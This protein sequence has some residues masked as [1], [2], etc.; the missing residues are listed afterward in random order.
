MLWINFDPAT[1]K[2]FVRGEMTKAA[3]MDRLAK[4]MG[5]WAAWIRSFKSRKKPAVGPHP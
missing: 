1:G 4:L 2:L 3:E 5:R